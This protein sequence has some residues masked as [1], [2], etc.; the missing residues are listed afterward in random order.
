MDTCPY[1]LPVYRYK[2]YFESEAYKENCKFRGT[3]NV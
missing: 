1:T 3:D 2:K